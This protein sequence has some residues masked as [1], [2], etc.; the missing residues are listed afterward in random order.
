MRRNYRKTRRSKRSQRR[1][2]TAR[3]RRQQ[4]G[5]AFEDIP[6]GATVFRRPLEG[7]Y[8]AVPTLMTVEKARKQVE[9]AG[10][11]L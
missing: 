11:L 7:D 9:E 10:S 2:R 1:K 5:G 8:M 4:R 6:A 3:Q